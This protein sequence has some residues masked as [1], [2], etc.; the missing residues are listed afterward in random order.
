[1]L[2]VLLSRTLKVQSLQQVRTAKHS[3]IPKFF[4]PPS[5]ERWGLCLFSLNLGLGLLGQGNTAEVMCQLRVGCRVLAVS[6][7]IIILRG[8]P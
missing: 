8:S 5:T 3:L 4:D 1:M 6:A 2:L 7:S